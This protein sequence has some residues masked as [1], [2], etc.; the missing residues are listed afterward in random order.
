M[1]VYIAE[2]HSF[3]RII[4]CYYYYANIYSI[5]NLIVY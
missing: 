5:V 4:T 1:K 3:R 2:A